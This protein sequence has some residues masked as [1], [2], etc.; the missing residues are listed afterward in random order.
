M[1][2]PIIFS[3]VIPLYNKEKY[4]ERSVNSVL[5]QSHNSFELIIVNDGSTDKSVEIINTLEDH[6]IRVINQANYG[7]AVARNTGIQIAKHQWVA[8][9]DADDEW[10]RSFLE[11][12][13]KSIQKI[14][15]CTAY[16]TGYLKIKLN[17]KLIGGK[18][19]YLPE[20]EGKIE[21]Y[22]KA[23]FFNGPVITASSVCLNKDKLKESNLIPLFPVGVKRGEDLEAWVL[24]ALNNDLYYINK[25]L[26]KIYAVK[27][28]TSYRSKY[29]HE[30]AF[31][32]RKWLDYCSNSSEKEYYLRRV[33][34]KKY[35]QLIKLL[36]IQGQLLKCII[37]SSQTIRLYVIQLFK[38]GRIRIIY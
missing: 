24:I 28:S 36:I 13:A 6:R 9:L 27:E 37:V 10:E 29:K 20:A 38:R 14:N 17:G 3:V 11:E 18:K 7:V 22:F 26:V 1:T 2:V 33:V 31:A 16:A 21:N 35:M 8:F 34:Y 12:I 32:Y 15:S 25:N 30:E 5:R 4:I 23:L 19:K